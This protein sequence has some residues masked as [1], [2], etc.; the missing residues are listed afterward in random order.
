M[1]KQKIMIHVGHSKTG[2]SAIQSCLAINADKLAAA[3]VTY[4]THQSFDLA[5]RGQ[6]SSGNIDFRVGWVNDIREVAKRLDARALLFS[7]EII[8]HGLIRDMNEIVTLASEFDVKIILFVREP[9]AMLFSTYGQA[10]KRHGTVISLDEFSRPEMHTIVARDTVTALHDHHISFEV[11]NYSATE[12]RLIP[13]F[14]RMVGVDPSVLS[15][16]PPKRRINRSLDRSE[17]VLQR[18]F[19]RHYGS[20][21]SQFISDALVNETPDIVA[22]KD[23]LSRDAYDD[24][25][26]RVSAAVA[27]LNKYLRHDENIYIAP[28]QD[29][30]AKV[31]TGSYSLSASQIDVLAASITGALNQRDAR[32]VELEGILTKA[33]CRPWRPLNDSARYHLALALSVCVRWLSKRRYEKFISSASKR[34]PRRFELGVPPTHK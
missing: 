33:L 19:N 32:V 6:I 23:L 13:E 30:W 15:E 25:V 7:S 34:D 14:A 28:Y 31:S 9:L 21:S 1:T 24:Y 18:A 12:N 3:G 20:S 10:V 5:G 4:P 26:V 16:M 8:F 29:D 22:E 2:S 17:M 27:E 11:R